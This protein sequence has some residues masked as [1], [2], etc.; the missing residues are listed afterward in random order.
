MCKVKKQA[1]IVTFISDARNIPVGSGTDCGRPDRRAAGASYWPLV[2]PSCSP[3]SRPDCKHHSALRTMS[4]TLHVT[5]V[6][7]LF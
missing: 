4:E 2:R 7:T 3:S 1:S 5:T 6:R